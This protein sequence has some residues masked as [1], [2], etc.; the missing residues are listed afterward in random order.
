MLL[1][2][3]QPRLTFHAVFIVSH[4]PYPYISHPTMVLSVVFERSA[5][6]HLSCS[7]SL[8][9]HIFLLSFTCLPALFLPASL[10]RSPHHIVITYLMPTSSLPHCPELLPSSP[11]HATTFMQSSFTPSLPL[12]SLNLS[13]YI[14]FTYFSSALTTPHHTIHAALL[15][16]VTLSFCSHTLFLPASL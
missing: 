5:T 11:H 10:Q 1:L 16:S 8:P 9:R 2:N 3:T 13:S 14:I 7:L 15:F 12:A 6:P 4:F